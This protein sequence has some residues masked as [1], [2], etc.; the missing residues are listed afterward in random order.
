M[1]KEFAKDAGVIGRKVAKNQEL[2]S[3][4]NFLQ[5]ISPNSPSKDPLSPNKSPN[6]F[7]FNQLPVFQ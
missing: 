5:P 7:N 2:S 1:A 3:P 6:K 4:T